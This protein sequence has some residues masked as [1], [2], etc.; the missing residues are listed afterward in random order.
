MDRR[1]TKTI[2][3][4]AAIFVFFLGLVI[5]SQLSS[6]DGDLGQALLFFAIVAV[7][8]TLFAAWI[9]GV[10]RRNR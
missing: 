1:R 5:Y 3:L 8:G 4:L 2:G 6:P 10:G 7:P 9:A